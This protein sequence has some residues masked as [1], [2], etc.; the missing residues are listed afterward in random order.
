MILILEYLFTVNYNW[1]LP[2]IV[3]VMLSNTCKNIIIIGMV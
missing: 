3:S 1:S 2:A